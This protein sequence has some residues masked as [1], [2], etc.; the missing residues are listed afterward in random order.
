MIKLNTQ[1]LKQMTNEELLVEFE[2][3]IQQMNNTK[4]FSPEH[5]E[6]HQTVKYIKEELLI[7]MNRQ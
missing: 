6:C 5:K 2:N 3:A 1:V 4:I 7:R